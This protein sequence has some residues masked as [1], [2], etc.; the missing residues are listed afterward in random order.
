MCIA[1]YPI[2][3]YKSSRKY[4]QAWELSCASFN[5]IRLPGIGAY[6]KLNFALNPKVARITLKS[7]HSFR[8]WLSKLV[9]GGA[10]LS[11]LVAIHEAKAGDEPVHLVTDWSHRHLVYSAPTSLRKRF[12]LSSDHRYVQQWLR[13]KA[14]KR[15]VRNEWRWHRAP[16]NPH[17]IQGDWSM[18]MGSGAKVGAGTYPAKYSF[19]ATSSNCASATQPDFVIYNTSLAGSTS[20]ATIVAFDNLYTSCTGGTPSTYWAY[21]TGT[22]GGAVTSPV[23]SFDGKQVAFVQ[24]SATGANLVILRWKA[25]N[26]TLASPIVPAAGPCTAATAPCMITV[27]FSTA[28]GAD[29]NTTDSFSSPFADYLGD[30]IYVGDDAGWLHKFTGVFGGTPAEVVATGAN[31]WPVNLT[32]GFG[33]LNSPVFVGGS[34]N[35]VLVTDNDGLIYATNSTIGGFDNTSFNS[36][37]P[38]LASPGFEDAPLVDVTTGKIYLFARASSEF[39]TPTNPPFHGTPGVPSV[40]EIDIPAT[41]SDIHLA[42]YIQAVVSDAGATTISPA[43]YTG[44]FDDLYYSSGTNSGFMYACGTHFNG[45]TTVNALWAIAVNSGVMDPNSASLGPTLTTANVACSPITEFNNTNTG[46]DRIFLSVTGSARTTSPISCPSNTTGCIMSFDVDSV[47]NGSSGT[48]ARASQAG[49]TSGIVID[50]SSAAGGASQVYFTPLSDQACIGSGGVGI[51]TGG[52]AIQ[53]SQSGL[54]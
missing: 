36:L 11:A 21:N 46:N 45:T 50:N 42:A 6:S 44:T 30:T 28:G 32:T 9:I 31:V 40:F 51:G 43:M 26:G 5:G 39:I 33:H 41:P 2:G 15:D 37:D 10:I 48:S 27:P 35:E 22:T 38:K 3:T 20:Q 52:C 24:N 47:L 16:E 19:D 54:N 1:E 53:A 8:G 25:N 13:R 23:L 34:F 12:Q 17:E 4:E 18:N 49:G 14:E 29:T 7:N